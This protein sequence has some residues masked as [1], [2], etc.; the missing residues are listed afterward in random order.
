M[1]VGACVVDTNVPIV[2]NG[3]NDDVT[4]ECRFQAVDF[5][6]KLMAGGRLIVDQGGEVEGEYF[7]RLRF[8]YPGVGNRFIQHFFNAHSDRIDRL[9]LGAKANDG[10]AEVK[11]RG[12][13]KNFDKSDW[14][15][16]ALSIIAKRPVYVTVDTDW[17]IS[18]AHLKDI[19]VKLRFLCG[20]NQKDWFIS[21]AA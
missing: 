9:E 6:E 19:G 10:Y 3:D 1:S 11:F 8:G 20:K 13:L 12:A 14:K 16:A 2:A 17:A 18:E 4:F 7:G 21:A 15:F 5:L